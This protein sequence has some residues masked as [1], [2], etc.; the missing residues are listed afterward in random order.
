MYCTHLRTLQ[1]AI[2]ATL[3]MTPVRAGTDCRYGCRLNNMTITL[4]GEDCYGSIS[5]TTCAGLCETT[6]D[7]WLPGVFY[8][9][10]LEGCPPRTNRV[11]IPVA[12]SCDCIK[13]KTDNT[14]CDR[15]S[16]ATPSCVVNPLET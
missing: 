1:L 11:D 8:T 10:Y 2:M 7:F 13:C 14:N 4:E 15:I 9:A 6:K 12:K 16:M 3:W 5:I